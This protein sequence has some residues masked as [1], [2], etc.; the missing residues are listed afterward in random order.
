MKQNNWCVPFALAFISGK[1]PNDIVDLIKEERGETRAVRGVNQRHY[2]PVLAHLG[3]KIT[4]TVRRPGMTIRKWAAN[5]AKWGDKS[6]WLITNVGHMM[7]YRD[8]IIYDNGHPDGSPV[9]IHKYGVARLRDAWQ[10]SR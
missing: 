5:R 3:F 6:T 8:G 9:S 1:T 10:V 7:V 2:L 4:A